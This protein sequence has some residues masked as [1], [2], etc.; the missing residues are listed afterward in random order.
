MGFKVAH[1]HALKLPK[2]TMIAGS[3]VLILLI[4]FALL[5]GTSIIAIAT[6]LFSV[7]FYALGVVTERR[8]FFAEFATR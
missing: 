2:L 7:A 3:D 6:S 8:L 1:K 5:V 4:V